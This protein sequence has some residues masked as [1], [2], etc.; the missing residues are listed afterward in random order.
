MND[1]QMILG[2]IVF[3]QK[4][5]SPTMNP[6]YKHQYQAIHLTWLDR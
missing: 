5:Q 3:D 1:R 4:T 6:E 2:Q